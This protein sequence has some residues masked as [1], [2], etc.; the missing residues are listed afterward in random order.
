LKR[1]KKSEAALVNGKPRRSLQRKK[2][3]ARTTMGMMTVA[4]RLLDARKLTTDT[5]II[6]AALVAAP[7]MMTTTGTIHQSAT[8]V[9]KMIAAHIASPAMTRPVMMIGIRADEM[10]DT[11][12]VEERKTMIAT[13]DLENEIEMAIRNIVAVI[14]MFITTETPVLVYGNVD[15]VTLQTVMEMIVD[16]N[17]TSMM[18]QV[19]LVTTTE[20]APKSVKACHRRQVYLSSPVLTFRIVP[21]VIEMHRQPRALLLLHRLRRLSSCPLHRLRN[22]P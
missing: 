22:Q 3:E 12:T 14:E 5:K 10:T 13:N 18:S 8:M 11:Q 1:A 19:P 4:K 21:E 6:T 9:A 2:H 7:D 17:Q 15:Q 20:K 16:E